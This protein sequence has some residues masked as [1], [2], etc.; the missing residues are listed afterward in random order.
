MI[1][2]DLLRQRRPR[3]PNL[4]IGIISFGPRVVTQTV[5]VDEKRAHPGRDCHPFPLLQPP[6]DGLHGLR[7]KL[8]LGV[9]ACLVT[10]AE[11][12]AIGRGA[13]IADVAL[14]RMF[15]MKVNIGQ[16]ER[17]NFALAETAIERQEK[18]QPM[19]RPAIFPEKM[20]LIKGVSLHLRRAHQAR[21]FIRSER[22]AHGQKFEV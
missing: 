1:G 8:E 21:A 16:L 2:L 20:Q 18:E 19:E 3:I 22:N 17:P 13:G 15:L 9:D 14:M 4:R 11:N 12:P 6:F 10:H 5:V 7:P